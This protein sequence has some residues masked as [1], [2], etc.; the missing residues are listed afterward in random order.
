VRSVKNKK[1]IIIYILLGLVFFFS[2][3]MAAMAHPP[4]NL[5][6]EYDIQSQK[7]TVRIDHGSFMPS[8]HYI[9]KVDVKKN[10]QPVINQTYKSQPDKNPFEYT[11]EITAKAGDVLEITASCNM[12]GSKTINITIAKQDK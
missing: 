4:K 10:G 11:Y 8:M 9:N 2:Y 1:K 5:T 6:A 12:Y 3:P 7:L